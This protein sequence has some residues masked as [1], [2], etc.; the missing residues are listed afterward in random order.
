MHVVEILNL[1][2]KLLV[3]KS[4]KLNNIEIQYRTFS[5]INW[6]NKFSP[7]LACELA[8]LV[9]GSAMQLK[10]CFSFKVYSGKAIFR[11]NSKLVNID[12]FHYL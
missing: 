3:L 6:E 4:N 9:L 10:T 1:N 8:N 12:L 2:N 7:I 5:G 11:W